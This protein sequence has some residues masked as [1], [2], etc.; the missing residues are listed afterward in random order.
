MVRN[1]ARLVVKGYCQQE[2]IDYEET[3]APV[4][5]LEVVRIFLAYAAS[6]N[7]QVYQMDVKCAF[8]NGEL[9]ETVYVEQPP[10]FV[11]EK[12]P[13]HCYILDKAVYG[14]K[15]APRAWYETLTKF[16]KLSNFKQ[17]AV[18]PTLFRKKVGDHLMMV[19]IYVDD[20]IFG[21]TC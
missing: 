9:E 5:R 17:G 14:L 20:I 6:K 8:L 4:A 15:Q 16:L 3:F 21:S 19:Q 11:N 7:F 13:D 1:K 12:F 18:D 2:G 10:G